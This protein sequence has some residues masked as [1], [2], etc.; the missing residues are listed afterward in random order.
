[1][2]EAMSTSTRV[3]YVDESILHLTI[4]DAVLHALKMQK[5]VNIL[6]IFILYNVYNYKWLQENFKSPGSCWHNSETI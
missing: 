6:C 2:E 5:F 3:K 4:H 1:M